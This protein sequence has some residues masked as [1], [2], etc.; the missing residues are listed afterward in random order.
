VFVIG[1]SFAGTAPG[2][3]FQ[4][5]HVPLNPDWYL[6]VSINAAMSPVVG[7]FGLLDPEGLGQALV[8]V[9]AGVA[10]PLVGLTV[11]H[12]YG[13]ADPASGTAQFASNPV[14]LAVEP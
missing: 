5:V 10:L 11:A 6:P 7:G 13:V 3:D 1:G 2:F 14:L 9:P 8:A 12:A 4:G